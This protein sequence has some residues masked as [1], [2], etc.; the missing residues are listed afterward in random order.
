MRE[1][2]C[3]VEEGLKPE[4]V[5]RKLWEDWK[6]LG[7]S[8]EKVGKMLGE[9]WEKIGRMLGNGWEKVWN[10]FTEGWK[11]VEIRLR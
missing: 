1:D 9:S 6:M 3:N 4:N 8:W 5:G 2:S 7:E 10:W 11:K